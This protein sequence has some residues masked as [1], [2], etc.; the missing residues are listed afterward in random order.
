MTKVLFIV[1]NL[2]VGGIQKITVDL[3]KEHVA[4]G[5][6]VDILQLE[7][8]LDFSID[9]D[10]NILK[11]NWPLYLVKNFWNIP[12]ILM[13]KVV[14]KLSFTSLEPI[15]NKLVYQGIV[16]STIDF[17]DYDVIFIRGA[18]SIKRTWWLKHPNVVFSLHLPY[19]FPLLSRWT[20]VNR[21]RSYALKAVFEKRNVFSVSKHIRNQFLDLVRC[22]C[23]D[24]GKIKVIY[25][26]ID[27]GNI[28]ILSQEKFIPPTSKPFMLGVGRLTK[29][30]NF[31]LLIRAYHKANV[32]SID[33][34]ILGDGYQKDKLL[35]LS[36]KL[37]IYERVHLVGF[38]KNPNPWFKKSEFFILS[39]VSEGFGN[40]ILESIANGTP[41]ISTKC[42]PVDEIL[43]GH[44]S[45]G[46]IENGDLLGLANKI[47]E[48][49][50]NP[51][52]VSESDIS[53]FNI[54]CIVNK[55]IDFAN[56]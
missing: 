38:V 28:N 30:K 21:V 47:Y 27:S 50:I 52:K 53:R 29:Q 18:R 16:K 17:S 32:T 40:V 49:S 22:Y 46:L 26:P 31:E 8:G 41:V 11:L 3:A 23:V 10:C 13:S 42:G 35:A 1:H 34:V 7:S 14:S 9:C 33:L 6:N 51:E 5:N 36:K 37:G 54:R 19:R 44:L 4:M 2:K 24:P 39:S 25:N 20:M 15:F 43:V 56:N 12:L 45:R 55:Q 48:Y